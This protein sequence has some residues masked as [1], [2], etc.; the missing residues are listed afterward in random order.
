MRTQ[1]QIMADIDRAY[2][3]GMKAGWNYGLFENS[4]GFNQVINARLKSIR[5]STRE[6]GKCEPKSK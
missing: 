3:L 5:E 6:A 2:V 1:E 4:E